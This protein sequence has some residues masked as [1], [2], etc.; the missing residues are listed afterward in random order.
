MAETTLQSLL[1]EASTDTDEAS[2]SDGPNLDDVL[3]QASSEDEPAVA[4]E[5]PRQRWASLSA[6]ASERLL[7]QILGETD[8]ESAAKT[9]MTLR[10]T[11]Q[12][13][14]AVAFKAR[15]DIWQGERFGS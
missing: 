6:S 1:A 12:T 7:E 15:D 5:G 11:G 14:E 9:T 2:C 3:G 13:S 10:H 4:D 8:G